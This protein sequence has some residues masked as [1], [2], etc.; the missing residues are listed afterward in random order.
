MVSLPS[1]LPAEALELG[2][3]ELLPPLDAL[4]PLL[5]L[6]PQAASARDAVAITRAVRQAREGRVN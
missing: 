6:P 4:L 2:A 5:L 3:D 1:P